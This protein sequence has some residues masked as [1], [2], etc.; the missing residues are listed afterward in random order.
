MK[1]DFGLSGALAKDEATGRVW[2][3]HVLKWSAASGK[4]RETY[5]V[6]GLWRGLSLGRVDSRSF[7]GTG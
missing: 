1:P 5:D 4:P 3:G 7:L 6:F 2:K